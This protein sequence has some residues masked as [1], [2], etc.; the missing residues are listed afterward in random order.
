MNAR[1]Y[2]AIGA[3]AT[4]A[5]VIAVGFGGSDVARDAATPFGLTDAGPFETTLSGPLWNDRTLRDRDS[6]RDIAFVTADEPLAIRVAA[7]HG[8]RVARVAYRIDG[9]RAREVF[10]CRA[11]DCPTSTTATARPPL[12][13]LAPGTH[14]VTV[15]VSGKR[16]GESAARTFEVTVADHPPAIG[17]G[18]PVVS[19]LPSGAGT[20]ISPDARASAL[21]TIAREQRRGVLR[22]V[23]WSSGTRVVQA[24]RLQAAGRAVGVTLLLSLRPARARVHATVPGYVP[25]PGGY[26][27][28]SVRFTADVLRDLLVDVD[29]QRHRV[30][31]VEPGPG[32]QTSQWSPDIEPAPTTRDRED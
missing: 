5:V 28:Q 9:G 15:V 30:I 18:E 2:V 23:L 24:G 7:H 10:A 4:A 25:R 11:G 27:G 12:R 26:R 20:G 19:R 1:A 6:V 21:R 29:L 17:E 14:R 22:D 13:A 31:S 3:G 32:S 16:T 8:A